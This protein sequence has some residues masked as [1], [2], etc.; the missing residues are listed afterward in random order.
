MSDHSPSDVEAYAKRVYD[1][2]ASIG[3]APT[4]EEVANYVSKKFP[5]TTSQEASRAYDYALRGGPTIIPWL[6]ELKKSDPDEAQKIIDQ[7]KADA[8]QAEDELR[9]LLFSLETPPEPDQGADERF[10]P[11]SSS[12]KEDYARR[13]FDALKKNGEDPTEEKITNAISKKFPGTTPEEASDLYDRAFA[14][15]IKKW[16]D[17]FQ[18]N[19]PEGYARWLA[20]LSAD[21]DAAGLRIKAR[22]ALYEKLEGWIGRAVIVEKTGIPNTCCAMRLLGKLKSHEDGMGSFILDMGTSESGPV[23]FGF[24]PSSVQKIQFE[25]GSSVPIIFMN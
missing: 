9:Q 7:W 1:K 21:A 3:E 13:A 4:S 19:D 15:Y 8:K 11:Q 6:E 17:E 12:E 23:F 2:L 24:Y 10:K 20:K 25:E 18:Q 5:G 14:S 22:L 16:Q